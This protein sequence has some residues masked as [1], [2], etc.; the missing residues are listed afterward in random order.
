MLQNNIHSKSVNYTELEEGERVWG[1][2]FDM[3]I[4]GPSLRK[5]PKEVMEGAPGKSVGEHSRWGEQTP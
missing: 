1:V 5:A 4:R 2:R 3:E